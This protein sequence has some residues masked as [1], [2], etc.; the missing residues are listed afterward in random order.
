MLQNNTRTLSKYEAIRADLQ[1]AALQQGNALE[2]VPN[3]VAVYKK[4]KSNITCFLIIS[5]LD[6]KCNTA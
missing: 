5:S 2:F 1:S 3:N 4:Y 6:E